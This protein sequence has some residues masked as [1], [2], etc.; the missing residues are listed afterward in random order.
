MRCAARPFISTLTV[1][2]ISGAVV[3]EAT[4]L[5]RLASAGL[6]ADRNPPP[7]DKIALGGK[8]PGDCER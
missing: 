4:P 8:P 7:L 1:I 5:E 2:D 6:I 3:N